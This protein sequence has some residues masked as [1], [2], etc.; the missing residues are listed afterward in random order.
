MGRQINFY[1]SSE[2]EA[3]FVAFLQSD[4]E[5][6]IIAHTSPTPAVVPI[7]ALP[8]RDVPGWFMLWLWN[9][10][11]SP[12]PTLRA[13]RSRDTTLSIVCDPKSLSFPEAIALMTVSLEAGFGRKCA[14][15]T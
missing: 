13:C 5:V 4:P 6:V 12:E 9:R 8:Q 1:M 7:V 11:I 15:G 14:T 2:D 10:A 3:E